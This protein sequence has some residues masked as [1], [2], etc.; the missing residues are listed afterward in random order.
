MDEYIKKIISPQ[1]GLIPWVNEVAVQSIY[2]AGSYQ[3]SSQ[4]GSFRELHPD[5]EMQFDSTLDS[6]RGAGCADEPEKS[7]LKSV[8]E[9]L[10]RYAASVYSPHEVVRLTPMQAKVKGFDLHQLP[11]LHLKKDES[12]SW[13]PVRIQSDAPIRWVPAINIVT[14]QETLAPLVLA[15]IHVKPE[16]NELFWPQSSCGLAAHTSLK[17]AILGALYELVERDSAQAIW[18]TKAPISKIEMDKVN[19]E[20]LKRYL[21][22]DSLACIGQHYF[23]ATSDVGIPTVYSLRELSPPIG[24]DVIISCSSNMNFETAIMKSRQEAMGRQLASLYQSGGA[25]YTRYKNAPGTLI[26]NGRNVREDISFLDVNSPRKVCISSVNLKYE[27]QYPSVCDELRAVISSISEKHPNIY[28]VNLTTRELEN[29]G[30]YV[31]RAIIPTMLPTSPSCSQKLLNM[32]RIQKLA[33]HYGASSFEFSN[34]NFAES[35]FF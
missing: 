30:V 11:T 29:L 12:E 8:F 14:K 25:L 34:L 22:E 26:Q 7:L 3:H 2:T 6:L 15:H 27:N 18:L 13:S 19:S 21:R 32:K 9:T 17:M 20:T 35:P 4:T 10:E 24:S 16:K 1:V 5:L 23:E 28:I 31:V 33:I